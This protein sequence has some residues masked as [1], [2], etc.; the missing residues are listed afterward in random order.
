MDKAALSPEAKKLFDLIEFDAD[1]KLVC[2]VKKH[3]FGLIL[4]YLTGILVAVAFAMVLV[5]LPLFVPDFITGETGESF[6]SGAAR[7]VVAIVGLLLVVLTIAMML[8]GAY[9]YTH[10]VLI[11]TSEKLA[12]VLYRTIFDRK[13]SQLSIGDIQDVTVNQRGVF[14]R[15]FKFGTIIVE[16]AGEQQNYTF[17]FVPEPYKAARAIV[18]SHEMNLRQ[19]G[20]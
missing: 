7:S 18:G 17:T 6:D 9:L 16:T 1:E 4:I 2:E 10:N 13:I 8:I 15:L 12:Q 14:A 3:P 5:A 11:V 20:N 19:Y